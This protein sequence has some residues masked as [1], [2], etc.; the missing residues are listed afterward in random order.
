MQSLKEQKKEPFKKRR[1]LK[2]F[3]AV[4]VLLLLLAISVIVGIYVISPSEDDSLRPIAKQ[5]SFLI[6]NCTEYFDATYDEFTSY[7]YPQ[8]RGKALVWNLQ[9]DS[10]DSSYYEL[11]DEIRANSSDSSVT[12]FFI[13]EK[14]DRTKF[15][16]L[17]YSKENPGFAHIAVVYWPSMEPAGLYNVAANFLMFEGGKIQEIDSAISNWIKYLPKT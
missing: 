13:K 15:Y 14:Y 3:A 2:I 16:G 12:V 4:A 6:E 1:F 7:E 10:I 9:S 11:P 8:L 5:S 17:G